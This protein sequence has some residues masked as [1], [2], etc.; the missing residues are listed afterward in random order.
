MD[1]SYLG[2]FFLYLLYSSFE[3]ATK[4]KPWFEELSLTLGQK[5]FLKKLFGMDERYKNIWDIESD[6]LKLFKQG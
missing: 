6:F 2:D 3:K 4:R 1:F 5:V